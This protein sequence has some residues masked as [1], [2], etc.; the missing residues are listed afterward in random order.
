MDPAG[1]YVY[2]LWGWST[3]LYWWISELCYEGFRHNRS[4]RIISIIKN[5]TSFRIVYSHLGCFSNILYKYYTVYTLKVNLKCTFSM[6]IN[7]VL[8]LMPGVYVEWHNRRYEY[9]IDHPLSQ[10]EQLNITCKQQYSTVLQKQ[11]VEVPFFQVPNV[12]K[13][14]F[15]HE[16]KHTLHWLIGPGT[17][18]KFN[19]NWKLIWE[20][21]FAKGFEV[22][23]IKITLYMNYIV[24]WFKQTL[25]D[26]Q[27]WWFV[28]YPPA[29]FVYIW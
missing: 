10:A 3:V 18:D 5:H 16:L 29:W 14:P 23:V 7:F 15:S 21:C 9:D 26:S 6:T 4:Y 20:Y 8:P 27:Q 17:L 25:C 28:G 11:Q 24:C 19:F 22:N 2:W 1:P 12:K 13:F